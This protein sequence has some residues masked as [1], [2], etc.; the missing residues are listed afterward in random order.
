MK[1]NVPVNKPAPLAFSSQ[2]SPCSASFHAERLADDVSK[3]LLVLLVPHP[4]PPPLPSSVGF[5]LT[6]RISLLCHTLDLIAPQGAPP[7]RSS[8]LNCPLQ[9][10]PHV[11]PLS[12]SRVPT[13]PLLCL[14]CGPWSPPCL[15]ASWTHP[16][17]I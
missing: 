5:S 13:K 2:A 16:G 7:L 4:R 12:R 3:W 14:H 15:R 8:S 6:S 1:L 11:L 17:S 9:P 10:R